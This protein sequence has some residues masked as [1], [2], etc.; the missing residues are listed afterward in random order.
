MFLQQFWNQRTDGDLREM[1]A[2]QLGFHS[3]LPD[4]SVSKCCNSSPLSSTLIHNKG[5][6]EVI[7]TYAAVKTL[8]ELSF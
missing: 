3:L 6:T 4:K 1:E 8:K 7:L 2:H 5:A